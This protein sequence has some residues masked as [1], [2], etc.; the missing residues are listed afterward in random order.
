MNYNRAVVTGFATKDVELRYTPKGTAVLS[1]T[2]AVNRYFKQNS[3]QKKETLFLDFVV[4]GKHAE[5]MATRVK[6]GIGVFIAGRL[7]QREWETD[8]GQ[9]RSKIEL[10]ADECDVFVP[11]E[12]DLDAADSGPRQAPTSSGAD[13]DDVP[14]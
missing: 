13:G 11:R 6:R 1:G 4:W 9:K 12:K 5:A 2:V 8:S 3:E 7:Q 10:V 14:F